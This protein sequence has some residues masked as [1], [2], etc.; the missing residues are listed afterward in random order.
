MQRI[1]CD[2]AGFRLYFAVFLRKI[3]EV[4]LRKIVEVFLP[5]SPFFPEKGDGEFVNDA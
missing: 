2:F 4:F 1:F 5:L 3:V